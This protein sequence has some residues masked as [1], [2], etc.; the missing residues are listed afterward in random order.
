MSS[1]YSLKLCIIALSVPLLF[2][3]N[4]SILNFTD[5]YI[6]LDYG[7]CGNK[8]S[9][10][11]RTSCDGGSYAM[12]RVTLAFFSASLLASF[13]LKNLINKSRV[14]GLKMALFP[15]L[16]GGIVTALAPNFKVFCIGRF[17]SGFPL[18]IST[19]AVIF[20]SEISPKDRRGLY[21]T[22]YGICIPAGQTIIYCTGL[23][24]PPV[25]QLVESDLQKYLMY[26]RATFLLQSIISFIAILGVTAFCRS[27]TP[28]LLISQGRAHEAEQ[29]LMKIYDDPS[30]VNAEMDSLLL[31]N[32]RMIEESKNSEKTTFSTLLSR[33]YFLP[34]FMSVVVTI[35]VSGSGIGIFIQKMSSLIGS[36]SGL[37]GEKII[38]IV[39]IISSIET[40]SCFCGGK[41]IE[42]YGRRIVG[43]VGTAVISISL[44]F[45]ALFTIFKDHFSSFVVQAV[46]IVTFTTFLVS[47]QVA[48]SPVSI[49]FVP[50]ALPTKVRSTG[51][52]IC[53][54][55]NW[56]ISSVY[57]PV[58]YIISDLTV[59]FLSSACCG[60]VSILCYFY[61]KETKGC[62]ISPYESEYSSLKTSEI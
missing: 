6:I 53:A 14:F 11:E 59:Y 13:T 35:A 29:V 28:C 10:I 47:F 57:I 26:C 9:F 44:L 24:L 17:I 33:K 51:M 2:G 55:V 49:A 34:M 1:Y 3:M 22:L 32:Q 37:P 36:A 46:P 50:E 61:M 40:L 7:L 38:Y 23:Y 18:G 25:S 19:A 60:M 54:F 20:I 52:G 42:R 30:V 48:I 58:S 4:I 15:Y 41:L 39:I 12:Y 8:G 27:E 56:L 21:A 31:S 43:I 5:P 45:L 62:T 16:I